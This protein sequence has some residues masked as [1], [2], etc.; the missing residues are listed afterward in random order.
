MRKVIEN[1]LKLGQTD[2]P[3]I[4][5]DLSWR[6]KIPQLFFVSSTPLQQP[7]DKK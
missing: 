3:N 5:I 1:Q 4:Q 6:D 7:S 2:I